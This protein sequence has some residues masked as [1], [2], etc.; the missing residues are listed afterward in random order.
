MA[1][2]HGRLS[3]LSVFVQRTAAAECLSLYL[4]S[5]GFWWAWVWRCDSASCH[6]HIRHTCR[7]V[8]TIPPP[9]RSRHAERE[10]EGHII[11]IPSFLIWVVQWLMGDSIDIIQFENLFL[12][13]SHS[14][15]CIFSEHKRL[16]KTYHK[17]IYIIQHYWTNQ[18]SLLCVCAWYDSHQTL[19][20]SAD[21]ER[22][23]VTA[24]CP[25]MHHLVHE[26]DFTCLFRAAAQ[27]TLMGLWNAQT[28]MKH[29]HLPSDDSTEPAL[30]WCAIERWG[31][32]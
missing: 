28:A 29:Q 26:D 13:N 31:K 20:S 2:T 25:I 18:T 11:H 14:I 7:P 27:L 6:P 12:H 9:Y 22:V 30:C 21:A 24:A 1:Q 17:L 5:S 4:S 8:C 23:S 3:G 15:Y 19:S 16:S 10:T 32:K